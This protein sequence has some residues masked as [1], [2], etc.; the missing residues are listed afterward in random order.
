MSR[1]LAILVSV[2]LSVT[3]SFGVTGVAA[4]GRP[5]AFGPPRARVAHILKA[6]DTAHLRYLNASGSLLFE[7]GKASGGLPGTMR[8]HIDIQATFT[9][10]FT[11]YAKGGSITGHGQATPHGEGTYESFAGTLVVTRGTRRYAHAHGKAGLYG[12]FDRDN[13]AFVVQ[14]TGTLLY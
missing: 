5:E 1:A 3:P 10:S 11:I 9:G 13:Y 12:T 8:A 6:S 7:E 2:G 4:S 14:T